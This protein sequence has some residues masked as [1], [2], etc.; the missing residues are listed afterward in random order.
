MLKDEKCL[1]YNHNLIL[2]NSFLVFFNLEQLVL[3]GGGHSHVHILLMLG[4]E[5][6]D[7]VQVTLV[8]RDVETPYSGMLPGHVAG[9][10]KRD[11][12]HLDLDRLAVFAGARLVHADVVGIDR[13]AKEVKLASSTGRPSLKY[14]V[15]SINIGSAP[16]VNTP[17]PIF[18]LFALITELVSNLM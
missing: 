18:N 1:Q 4:M 6:I 15:L 16:Q 9:L 11:D 12:C 10:Y 3:V 8:T 13:E 14:D 17:L 5:H 7:G 2:R